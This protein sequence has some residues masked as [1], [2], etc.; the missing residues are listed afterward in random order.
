MNGLDI[1]ACEIGNAYL[2]APCREKI[3][4]QAGPECGKQQGVVMIITRALYGLNSAGTSWRTMLSDTLQ[5]PEF[6]FRPPQVDQ[7]VYIRRRSRTNNTN[8]YEMVLVY[9]DDILCVSHAPKEFMD[10]IGLVFKLQES[11]KK[12]EIY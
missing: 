1:L 4:F 8:Y 3:W 5:S 11:I 10:K 6:G 9:V 2:N 12:P 7:D